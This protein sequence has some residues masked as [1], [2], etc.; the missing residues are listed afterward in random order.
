MREGC[1]DQSAGRSKL[2]IIISI[3]RTLI[4]ETRCSHGLVGS[5]GFLDVIDA[6]RIIGYRRIFLG[7]SFDSAECL[8]AS[9]E[10]VAEW[11]LVGHSA[12]GLS[13]CWPRIGSWTNGSLLKSIV[14]AKEL[15]NRIG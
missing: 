9:S 1:P 3:S 13:G 5:V 15:E 8:S 7:V 11:T 14:L 12:G 6:L 4:L 2:V 10:I